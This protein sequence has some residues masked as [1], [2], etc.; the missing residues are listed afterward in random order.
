[1][2]QG[3]APPSPSPA[4][5]R[6]VISIG[7]DVASAVRIVNTPISTV[8]AIKRFLRPNRS[9]IGPNVAAPSVAPTSAAAKIGPKLDILM[10]SPSA[11]MGAATPIDCVST[12][13]NR[14]TSA[15]QMMMP[16]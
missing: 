5:M 10:P 9:A 4:R 14:L 15:Q 12:P 6:N 11:M 13:S 7:T 8:A 2:K 16:I 1:M 3:V